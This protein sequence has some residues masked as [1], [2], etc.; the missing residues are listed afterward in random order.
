MGQLLLIID[1]QN[2]FV[3]Q[4]TKPIIPGIESLIAHFAQRQVPIAFTRFINSP[5]SPHVKWIG[6]SRLMAEPE[7][8]LVDTFCEPSATIFDKPGY[9]AF[10]DEFERFL[11]AQAIDRLILCGIATD[12]CILKTAVDAFERHIEPVVVQD[13]CASH[14]GR[15]VHN[16]GLLLISRFIG[17]RQ[18]TTIEE[19][20]KAS[21]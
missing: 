11:Q 8:N 14:A 5:A 6:W 1:M 7:I 17:K 2:G 19:I 16:A 18:I 13:A 20:I 15:E 9:T 3:N 4:E 10:T 21:H 12:G